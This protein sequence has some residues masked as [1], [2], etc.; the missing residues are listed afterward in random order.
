MAANPDSQTFWEHLDELRSVIL[1]SLMVAAVFAVA[2]FCFKEDLFDVVLSPRM[3]DSSPIDCF[4]ES[5][6]LS[7][8]RM[9]R[10]SLCNSSI[11][12]SQNSLSST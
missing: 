8:D 10:I 9:I 1:K 5:A 2:A 4:I 7:P 11:P 6:D 12:A 3:P